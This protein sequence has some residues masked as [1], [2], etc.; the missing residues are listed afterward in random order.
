M[1]AREVPR[2]GRELGV[3][4]DKRDGLAKQGKGIPKRGHS[5]DNSPDAG[6]GFRELTPPSSLDSLTL[7][8]R[9]SWVISLGKGI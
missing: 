3:L 8:A 1:K 4:P 6:L 5:Q 7:A 2:K 9:A